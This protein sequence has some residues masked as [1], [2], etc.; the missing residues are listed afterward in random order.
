VGHRSEHPSCLV[1]QVINAALDTAFADAEA[2]LLQRFESVTLA[3]LAADFTRR[4]GTHRS[5]HRH[6]A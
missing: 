2:L 4:H 5:R 3:A 6:E 1:E